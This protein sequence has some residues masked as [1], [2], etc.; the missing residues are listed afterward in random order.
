MEYGGSVTPSLLWAA[1]DSQVKKDK[2][3]LPKTVEQLME[4]WTK[5]PSYPIVKVYTTESGCIQI[6]Q[7]IGNPS[8]RVY[9]VKIS[10]SFDYSCLENI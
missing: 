4:P 6:E 10:I 5:N 8:T 2:I 9:L 1:F 3:V 7:V